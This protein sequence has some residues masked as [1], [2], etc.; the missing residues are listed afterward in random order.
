M[1]IAGIGF[2]D[3][4]VPDNDFIWDIF[5]DETSWY[6]EIFF[7]VHVGKGAIAS[8]RAA[9]TIAVDHKIAAFVLSG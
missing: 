8:N 2:D 3:F 1:G 7:T 6:G 9:E 5:D 4:I